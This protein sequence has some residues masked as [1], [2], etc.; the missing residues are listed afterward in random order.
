MIPLAALAGILAVVAFN[1]IEWHHIRRAGGRAAL[2]VIVTTFLVTI[3][4]D[5]ISGIA[6]GMVLAFIIQAAM[7][8]IR[9]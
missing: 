5:L 8:Q 9:P 2:A 1:M 6:A 7:R 3:F 4:R